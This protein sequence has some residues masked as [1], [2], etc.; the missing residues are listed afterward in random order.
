M[1]ETPEAIFKALDEHF[2]S[3]RNVI[4]ESFK[5]NVHHPLKD[6]ESR[7][8]KFMQALQDQQTFATSASFENSSSKTG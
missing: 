2:K 7:R 6:Q 3:S 5:F 8:K 4:Y 1:T